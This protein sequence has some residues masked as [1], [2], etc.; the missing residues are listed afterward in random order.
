MVM[1]MLAFSPQKILLHE[2]FPKAEIALKF[3]NLTQSMKKLSSTE[4]IL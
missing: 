3:Q 1:R 2:K 4:K